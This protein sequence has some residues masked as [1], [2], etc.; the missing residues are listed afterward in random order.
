MGPNYH[1]SFNAAFPSGTTH[2]HPPG[3]P[4]AQY[5]F[6]ALQHADFTGV[7][8]E[9]WRDCGWQVNVTINASEV[10]LFFAPFLKISPQ[11]WL[12]CCTGD[13]G[14]LN[15][16]FGRSSAEERFQ[17]ARVIHNALFSDSR[18]SEIRWYPKSEAGSFR[19]WHNEPVMER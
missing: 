18:F 6:G 7:E 19:R 12:L 13:D 9:N 16:A 1:V 11:S 14:I 15:R 10:Y 4:I 2:S 8:I 5:F 3:Y 17:L